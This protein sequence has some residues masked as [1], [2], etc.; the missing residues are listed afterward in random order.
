MLAGV[1]LL[2]ARIT[3]IEER[4]EETVNSILIERYKK[5][6]RA[7]YSSGIAQNDFVEFRLRQMDSGFRALLNETALIAEHRLVPIGDLFFRNTLLP[8]EKRRLIARGYV[9]RD[10]IE[11]RLD[12]P[13]VTPSERSMLLTQLENL[14]EE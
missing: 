14:P 3:R 5:E 13:D 11:Q 2:V 9:P 7:I 10:L 8:E 12:D 1:Q 4:V 6:M